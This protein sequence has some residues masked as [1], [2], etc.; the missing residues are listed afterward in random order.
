MQL[1][2]LHIRTDFCDAAEDK[3]YGYAGIFPRYADT[4]VF[5]MALFHQD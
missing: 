1:P 3:R 5:Q 2:I 4:C